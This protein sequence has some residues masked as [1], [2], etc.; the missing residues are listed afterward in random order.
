MDDGGSHTTIPYHTTLTAMCVVFE[1]AVGY[2][3][4][5]SELARVPTRLLARS[6]S[7]G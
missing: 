3:R 7:I 2:E 1:C 4:A 5:N 6:L